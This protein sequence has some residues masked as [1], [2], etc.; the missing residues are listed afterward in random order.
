M[1]LIF[2]CET[3]LGCCDADRVNGHFGVEERQWV[4]LVSTAASVTG[5][6]GMLRVEQR[7]Y[8]RDTDGSNEVRAQN[9][10]LPELTLEPLLEGPEETVQQAQR[11]HQE[12]VEKARHQLL[13]QSI[14]SRDGYTV[15]EISE[16]TRP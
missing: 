16:E 5:T 7:C 2:E 4:A 8:L 13:E 1:K 9:W 3:E 15:S 6:K 10:V 14:L 11:L 12:F